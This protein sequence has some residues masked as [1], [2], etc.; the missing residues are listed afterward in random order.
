MTHNGDGL[1]DRPEDA[2][3][4]PGVLAM[5]DCFEADSVNQRLIDLAVSY[6]TAL[7][8]DAT[9][10]DLRDLELPTYEAGV[11]LEEL[12]VG[13]HAFRQLLCAHDGFLIALPSENEKYPPLLLNAIAWSVCPVFGARAIGAYSRKCASLMSATGES[14]ALDK[15]IDSVTETLTQLGVLVLPETLILSVDESSLVA[16]GLAG[17]QAWHE[18]EAQIERFIGTVKWAQAQSAS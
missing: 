1:A 9:I 14:K 4:V 15:R 7:G 2:T 5:A 6:A 12:P 13:A 8:T 17:R 18:L 16:G 10:L 11:S 3:F